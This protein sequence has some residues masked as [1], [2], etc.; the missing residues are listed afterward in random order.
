MRGNVQALFGGEGLVFLS[1]Q[2]LA[3]YPTPTVRKTLG[4]LVF[5]DDEPANREAAEALELNN[6]M[7]YESL[8]QARMAERSA[9]Y[10]ELI[11]D[12]YE[13]ITVY[14]HLPCSMCLERTPR[15]VLQNCSQWHVVA[16]CRNC[17]EKLNENYG[18]RADG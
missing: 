7:C 11:D 10:Q 6:V 2:D 14:P 16:L 17:Q 15:A 18:R 9:M 5:I 13:D 1:N 4:G 12:G 3:S 8:E